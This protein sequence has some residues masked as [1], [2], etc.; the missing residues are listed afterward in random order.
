MP[1]R[2]H[3]NTYSDV[4][5]MVT[6]IGRNLHHKNSIYELEAVWSKAKYKERFLT[7]A[8]PEIVEEV[9]EEIPEV[10]EKEVIDIKDIFD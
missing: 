3:R 9:K 10:E 7:P 8:E 4:S 5:G 1:R 2:L 6:P